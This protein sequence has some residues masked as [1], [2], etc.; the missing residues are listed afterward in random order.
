MA[1][2]YI[3]DEL[4]FWNKAQAISTMLEIA[5]HFPY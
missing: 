4:G 2:G 5:K 1:T 3:G